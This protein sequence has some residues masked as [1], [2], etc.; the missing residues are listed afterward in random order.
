MSWLRKK[1]TRAASKGAT[2]AHRQPFFG[3]SMDGE[4]VREI[5]ATGPVSWMRKRPER[6][7][8]NATE[9]NFPEAWPRAAN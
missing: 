8:L 7:G 3:A 4:V 6:E 5:D 9:E 2:E 1:A